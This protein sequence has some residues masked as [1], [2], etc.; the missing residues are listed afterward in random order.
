MNYWAANYGTRSDDFVDG[1]IA[2]V[3]AYATWKDGE[4]VVGTSNTPLEVVTAEI[5]RG[6]KSICAGLREE[7][8]QIG[9]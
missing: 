8:E 4:Q 9:L 1:A 5:R 3:T 7:E 6:M 2:G